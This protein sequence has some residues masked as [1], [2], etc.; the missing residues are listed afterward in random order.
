[1]IQQD[2]SRMARA[3]A[4]G[5]QEPAQ[6]SSSS[7]CP[8][9]CPSPPLPAASQLTPPPPHLEWPEQPNADLHAAPLPIGHLGRWML[10]DRIQVI[11]HRSEPWLRPQATF[12]KQARAL[13][14]NPR[15][16]PGPEQLRDAPGRI[17]PG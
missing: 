1:M 2:R 5:K 14:V 13:V 4:I 11:G 15:Y 7:L 3:G 8:P 12:T 6:P 16:T 10:E 17:N 9:P